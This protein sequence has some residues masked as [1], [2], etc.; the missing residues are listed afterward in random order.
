MKYTTLALAVVLMVAVAL[1]GFARQKH[2]NVTRKL[3]Q[4]NPLDLWKGKPSRPYTVI[5]PVAPEPITRTAGAIA[6]N[7]AVIVHLMKK[8]IHM[9]ADEVININCT[10]QPFATD[11][12]DFLRREPW[13]AMWLCPMR[14]S[15]TAVKY[16]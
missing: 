8:A 14:C 6:H 10:P 13:I 9:K 5:G 7:E 15:G 12:G 2:T 11:K 4:D 16:K 1:P 3:L